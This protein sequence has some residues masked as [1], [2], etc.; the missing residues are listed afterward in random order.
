MNNSHRNIGLFFVFLITIIFLGLDIFRF[1]ISFSNMHIDYSSVLSSY[2][3][4]LYTRLL[5]LAPWYLYFV[6]LDIDSPHALHRCKW[7]KLLLWL[8]AVPLCITIRSLLGLIADLVIP[9]FMT[10]IDSGN[11]SNC[12]N[13]LNIMPQ[14]IYEVFS[15]LYFVALGVEI[16]ALILKVYF[17]PYIHSNKEGQEK[18]D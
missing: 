15:F 4:I 3:Q 10:D 8:S 11:Y 16:L 6:S 14:M 18:C 17:F 2:D 9:M 5:F 1:G 12:H 7:F 13:R